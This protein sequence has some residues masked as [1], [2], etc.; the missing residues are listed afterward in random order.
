M[1]MGVMNVIKELVASDEASPRALPL[2]RKLAPN[3]KS[4]G[5]PI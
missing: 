5:C 3:L 2:L 1:S 4:L